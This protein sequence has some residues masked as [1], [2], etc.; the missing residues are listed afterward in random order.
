MQDEVVFLPDRRGPGVLHVALIAGGF[1]VFVQLVFLDGLP[2]RLVFT[3]AFAVFL[4][5]GFW[6]AKRHAE[7]WPQRIVINRL[8]I[9]CD[10]MKAQHGVD[11]IPWN[12]VARMDLFYTDSRLPP[13]LR[14]G[15]KP[16]AFRARMKPSRADRLGMGLDANIP[17]SVNATPEEVLETAERYWQESGHNRG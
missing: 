5:L 2:S 12:V 15:L 11:S 3:V 8:G 1:F 9:S 16:G 17:V 14:I 6:L 7:S 13:H 4:L 10:N